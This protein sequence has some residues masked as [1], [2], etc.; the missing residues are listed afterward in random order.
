MESKV[1]DPW[2]LLEEMAAPSLPGSLGALQIQ[3]GANEST[4]DTPG[5]RE[6]VVSIGSPVEEWQQWH[7]VKATEV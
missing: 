5:L 6:K 2:C 7:L 3:E 4:P 1:M